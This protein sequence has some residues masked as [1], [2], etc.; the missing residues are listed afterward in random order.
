MIGEAANLHSSESDNKIYYNTRKTFLHDSTLLLDDSEQ[1]V[2]EYADKF[3]WNLNRTE[4]D[5]RC[6]L[7]KTKEKRGSR[8][9]CTLSPSN[10]KAPI[11]F[12]SLKNTRKEK[13]K[14][15]EQGILDRQNINVYDSCG[16]NSVRKKN[17]IDC[18]FGRN[19][20]R[21]DKEN[22]EAGN[23][24]DKPFTNIP[25]NIRHLLE[26][27]MPWNI[28]VGPT[29]LQGGTKRKAQIHKKKKGKCTDDK[30]SSSGS[31]TFCFLLLCAKD[32]DVSSKCYC[33]GSVLFS[34]VS[35][36]F[37]SLPRQ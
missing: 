27:V 31:C 34:L 21:W 23:G 29:P 1:F 22:E 15:Q 20:P 9:V 3:K 12:T 28:N 2:T 17:V 5:N 19:M 8:R 4:Q 30:V 18:S 14:C 11:I 37:C 16:H 33:S 25:L 32:G 35:L 36:T 13:R 6:S 26:S 7:K 10:N 24:Q